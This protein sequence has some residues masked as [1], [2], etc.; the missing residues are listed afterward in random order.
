[1]LLGL[2]SQTHRSEILNLNTLELSTDWRFYLRRVDGLLA[3]AE[4]SNSEDSFFAQSSLDI[5]GHHSGLGWFKIPYLFL[6]LSHRGHELC[7]IASA[8]ERR[9]RWHHW[10]LHN[11]HFRLRWRRHLHDFLK[12]LVGKL[13]ILQVAE[14]MCFRESENQ[15]GSSELLRRLHDLIE[16]HLWS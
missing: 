3:T 15:G 13:S 11:L 12:V 1:M 4:A 10:L 14:L 16:R 6:Y 8:Y 2:L 5:E 9:F 7:A